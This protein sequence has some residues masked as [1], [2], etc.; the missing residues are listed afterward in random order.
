M[1]QYRLLAEVGVMNQVRRIH[2]EYSNSIVVLFMIIKTR[3][4]KK[5]K[6]TGKDQATQ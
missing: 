6:G 5:C 4:P 2:R 1:N 3:N